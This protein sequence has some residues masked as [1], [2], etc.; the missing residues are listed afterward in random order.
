MA[1]LGRYSAQRRKVE[2]I[3][4]SAAAASKTVEVADCGTLFAIDATDDV[5]V[6]MPAIAAAGNGWWCEFLLKTVVGGGKSVVISLH[7]DDGN[8]DA[9]LIEAADSGSKVSVSNSDLTLAAACPAG[10]RVVYQLADGK[11]FIDSTA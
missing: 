2:A 10:T 3:D 7:A 1:K 11:F 4:A 8:S 5:T 9:L 6:T